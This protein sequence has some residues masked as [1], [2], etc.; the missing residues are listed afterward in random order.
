MMFIEYAAAAGTPQLDVGTGT[1]RAWLA[2]S[3][4]GPNN[5]VLPEPPWP[6]VSI[7]RQG[8]M[9]MNTNPEVL[10]AAARGSLSN[11]PLDLCTGQF[12]TGIFCRGT[13]CAELVGI[14]A[15]AAMSS[16]AC[17]STETDF[18][19]VERGYSDLVNVFPY[20]FCSAAYFICRDAFLQLAPRKAWVIIAINTNLSKQLIRILCR[21][22]APV[23]HFLARPGANKAGVIVWKPISWKYM[24]TNLEM[25][26]PAAISTKT[27][28]TRCSWLHAWELFDC[29]GVFAPEAD[30]SSNC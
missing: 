21:N 17:K 15:V 27:G 3:D 30:N 23:S 25:L 12:F 5:P 10:L 1:M 13:C 24:N 19:N 29:G 26:A 20:S 9:A 2:T 16:A 4:G 18:G 6:R 7:M 22:W 11:S 14:K 28:G 8:V